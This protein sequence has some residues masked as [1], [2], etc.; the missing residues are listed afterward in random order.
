M[1]TVVKKRRQIRSELVKLASRNCS[2]GGGK[3]ATEICSSLQG[4]HTDS[5]QANTTLLGSD[6]IKQSVNNRTDICLVLVVCELQAVHK[7]TILIHFKISRWTGFFTPD[8]SPATFI[9]PEWLNS[10]PVTAWVNAEP[11]ALPQ[12]LEE[13]QAR[14]LGTRLLKPYKFLIAAPRCRS[15]WKQQLGWLRR[16]ISLTGVPT[17]SLVNIEE[18]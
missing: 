8:L 16:Q 2:K 6:I 15:F 10:I 5:I 1:D 12:Y 9:L 13:S 3:H 18:C 4:L 11:K 17:P 14:P 7:V